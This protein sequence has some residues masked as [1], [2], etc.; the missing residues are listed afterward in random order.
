MKNQVISQFEKDGVSSYNQLLPE[1]MANLL[2]NLPGIVYRCV[3]DKQW[4]MLFLSEGCIRLTGD[5]PEELLYNEAISFVDLI[6]EDDIDYVSNTIT[7]AVETRTQY[8]LEY[9]L[10][11]KSGKM[12]WVWEQGN[13]IYNELGEAVYLDGVIGDISYKK[14]TEAKLL[15]ITQD[16]KKYNTLK[17][18]FFNIIAHDL[19]NPIYAIISLAEFI[20]YNK[21]NM[22]VDQIVDFCSQI[23]SSA[24][25]INYHLDNLLEWSRIQAGGIKL[26]PSRIHIRKMISDVLYSLFKHSSDKQIR[27]EFDIEEELHVITD[28]RLLS[29]V[30][31]NIVSNAI[32]Y[33]DYDQLIKIESGIMEQKLW[34]RVTDQGIGIPR[35]VLAGI[36][37][38]N[39]DSPR[40]GTANEIGKGMGLILVK[41]YLE[42]L[43]GEIHLESKLKKGTK[44][45]LFLPL[46]LP[47]TC[48]K[49]C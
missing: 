45:E 20:T 39:Q 2:H 48:G 13:A 14:E 40:K 6:Y 30:M 16:L 28:L 1:L 38:D 3:Y 11:H 12:L 7:K 33:S 21:E 42:Q 24:Q 5:Q 32:K 49:C 15:A 23:H 36:F 37:D 47:C 31:R 35:S 8:Q 19:Q 41:N 25:S 43:G 22:S 29:S 26:N 17:D 27:F 10:R 18:K 34:I 4:T 9:R 44:V 46:G